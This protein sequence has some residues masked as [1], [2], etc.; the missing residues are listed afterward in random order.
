MV[1]IITTNNATSQNY[2]QLT[3]SPN[4]TCI[5]YLHMYSTGNQ[6]TEQ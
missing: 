4:K 5:N 1:R 2:S 6:N 3:T